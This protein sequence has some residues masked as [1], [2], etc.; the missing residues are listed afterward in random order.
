MPCALLRGL[1]VNLAVCGNEVVSFYATSDILTAHMPN[2]ASLLKDEITRLARK[3]VKA[4]VEPMRKQ[5]TTQRREIAA[6][7]R[8]RD[9][10]KR[11]VSKVGRS[12][13]RTVTGPGEEESGR[14]TRFSSGGF[15]TLRQKLGLS[16]EQM[17]RLTGV[18]GQSIY[19]WE[20]GHSRPRA[21][22]LQQIVKVR[23]LGKR[24]AH[25]WLDENA[26]AG[27]KKRASTAR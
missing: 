1:F 23:T 18:S 5:L 3:E 26:G 17:G 6:L 8:D 2:I 13:P 7:K 20:S 16:A 27:R 25:Q 10:L 11:L 19:N 21:T 22:Q 9:Q 15:K 12:A 4:A 24:A 14:S